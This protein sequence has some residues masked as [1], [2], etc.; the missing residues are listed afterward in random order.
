[1]TP[2][3]R[4]PVRAWRDRGV[5]LLRIEPAGFLGDAQ[6]GHGRRRRAE[7]LVVVLE[8]LEQVAQALTTVGVDRL[9]G[10]M[11]DGGEGDGLGFG[12]HAMGLSLRRRPATSSPGLDAT[13]RGR[14]TA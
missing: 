14:S 9:D 1:L 4:R 2:C 6:L 13:L 8:A 5:L 7:R 3:L 12:R 11:D 10:T